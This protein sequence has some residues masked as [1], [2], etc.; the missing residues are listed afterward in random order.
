M[1]LMVRRVRVQDIPTLEHFESDNLKRFPGRAGWMEAYRRVV[2]I[3][4]SEEPEGILVAEYEGRAVGAAIVRARQQH[5][6]TGKKYGQLMTLTVAHGWRGQ[7]VDTRLLRESEAY[8]RSRGCESIAI[9][10]PADAAEDA[11]L[12]KTAGYRVLGWELERPL[13]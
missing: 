13:K 3:S 1:P 10:L 9:N 8:L 6:V 11:E 7:G 2:E 5:P 4:L 12:F